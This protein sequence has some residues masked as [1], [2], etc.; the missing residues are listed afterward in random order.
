MCWVAVPREK[1]AGVMPSGSI[2]HPSNLERVTLHRNL[3]V[4]RTLYA[5]AF[6]A[7]HA[8]A[9]SYAIS[10]AGEPY[11][12]ALE[13]AKKLDGNLS[14]ATNATVNVSGVLLADIT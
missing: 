2:A 5:A 6:A 10:T 12:A 8:I 9:V 4:Q 14:N 1:K 11:L 13:Q 3:P 7:F